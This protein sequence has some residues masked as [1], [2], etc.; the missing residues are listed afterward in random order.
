MGVA[1]V[2]RWATLLSEYDLNIRHR[3]GIK[4]GHVDALSRAPTEKA[5]D[6]ELELM[7][8]RLEVLITMSEKDKVSAMQRTDTSLKTIVDVLSHKES[9]RSYNEEKLIQGYTLKKGL[10]YKEIMVDNVRRKLWVVPKSMR[11]SLVVRFHDLEGHFAVERTVRKKLKSY[12]FARMRRY[13][14]I[15]IRF[16]PECILTKTPHGKQPR[17]LHPILPG[18]RPFEIINMD[19]IGPV[20]TSPKGNKY[21]LVVINN[22]T[23]YVKLYPVRNCDTEGVTSSLQSFILLYGVPK[24]VISDRGIAFTSKAFQE[25]CLQHG[26][27]HRLNSVRHPQ[28]NGQV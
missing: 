22:L 24:R 16:C 26:I 25:F 5:N 7:D 3:P 23:K 12:Y 18:R 15:H 27:H 2:A 6:T 11:K 8:E 28:A 19:H 14:R 21:V 1:Y 20:V 10:S 4:I 9:E 17:K 13:V